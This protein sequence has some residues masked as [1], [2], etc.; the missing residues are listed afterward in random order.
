MENTTDDLRALSA[1]DLFAHCV[2]SGIMVQPP[3]DDPPCLEAVEMLAEYL[4]CRPGCRV[5]SSKTAHRSPSRRV[6]CADSIHQSHLET[7]SSDVPSRQQSSRCKCA[8]SPI[9]VARQDYGP[10][11]SNP[12]VASSGWS[13]LSHQVGRLWQ[14]GRVVVLGYCPCEGVRANV[15]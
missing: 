3:A 15:V 1:S 14:R 7:E 11:A 4:N 5:K 6:K 12:C 13:W 8:E 10:S 9:S 2:A